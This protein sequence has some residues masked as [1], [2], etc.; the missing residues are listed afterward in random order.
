M[1]TTT[2]PIA[3]ATISFA[4]LPALGAELEG[5]IFSGITTL[6]D[7]THAA[8]ILLPNKA[9]KRMTWKKATAWAEEVGGQLPSRPVAALLYANAKPHLDPAWH[10][11][12]DT[13]D[14]DTGDD[15]DASYA[16]LCNFSRGYQGNYRKS[17]EG[18][19][20]AVRLIH[21]TA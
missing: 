8:V 13:L 12:S 4:S 6:K 5:G 11:T 3:I 14:Q 7:G 16:W 10:W 1:D 18:A 15:S 2:E 21:L 19:A 20:R 9:Q 17:D